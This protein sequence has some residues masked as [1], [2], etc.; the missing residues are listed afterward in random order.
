MT[1]LK[2]VAARMSGAVHRMV[3]RMSSGRLLGR[4]FGMP[5]IELE[6]VGR[7]SGKARSTM[8]TTPLRDDDRM[9]LV[10]SYGGDDRHPAWFL[11]LRDNPNVKVTANGET[12][13]MT[14]RV[15]TAEEKRE[16]WPQ[17]TATYQGYAKYE[18]KTDRDIPLVILTD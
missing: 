4:A 9:V 17:V 14:A 1:S 3:Y 11:N 15:A 5:V 7:R 18:S 12:R 8:L 13:S 2:D 16:L 10:A 6:T